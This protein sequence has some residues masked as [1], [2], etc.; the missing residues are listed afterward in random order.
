MHRR[1]R[2]VPLSGPLV[3]LALWLAG[4]CLSPSCRTSLDGDNG[5]SRSD[6]AVP[7]GPKV[8][9]FIID[10]P[11]LSEMFEDPLHEHVPRIWNDLRPQGA[12]IREFWNS[13]D[14]RT[15]PGHSSILSGTWQYIANDGTERPHAP[16]LFEY[17]RK[18]LGAP[19]SQ[20][21]IVTGKDKLRSCSY[22]THPEY[23]AAYAATEDGPYAGD[24]AVCA[25]LLSVLQSDAPR[26]VMACFPTVDQAGHAGSW[27]NYVAAI[28]N[29]D[30]L[31]YHVWN[32]LQSDTAY[33]GQTYM[34][35]TADHGRHDDAHGGF[36]NHGDDCAGCRRLPFLAL[37]PDI[38]AGYTADGV[39]TQRD[40]CNTVAALLDFPVPYAEGAVIEEI[41][42]PMITGI[43]P[44]G[45]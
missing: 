11:R 7:P 24:N 15:N 32:Y 44:Q 4:L 5:A 39:Y 13:G 6:R 30:S 28:E 20:A 42:Q 34:F 26:L 38:R 16:T 36:Q 45:R 3:A 14:T 27:D 12:I 40:I 22:S 1:T 21:Y 19:Q 31:A 33:A 10:G 2:P 25:E 9:L 29:V 17:M 41:F 35:V 37:G 43:K 8:V 23:G 18:T